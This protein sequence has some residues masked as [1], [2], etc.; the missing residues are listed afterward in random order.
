MNANLLFRL[1][2]YIRVR[3]IVALFFRSPFSSRLLELVR[4]EEIPEFPPFGS[5]LVAR[6]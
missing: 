3:A 1:L 6:I 5:G 2:N 4:D